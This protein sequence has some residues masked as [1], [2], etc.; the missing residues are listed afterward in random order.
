MGWGGRRGDRGRSCGDQDEGGKERGEARERRRGEGRERRSE[1]HCSPSSN[2]KCSILTMTIK[3]D[4]KEATTR[5]C[6]C[7]YMIS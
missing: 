2:W 6:G 4:H 3:N 7:A 5:D 1:I